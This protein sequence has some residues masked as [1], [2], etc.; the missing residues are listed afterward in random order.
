MAGAFVP[1]RVREKA[2]P[3]ASGKIRRL[4]IPT[5]PANREVAPSG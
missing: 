1:Q 2:I 4:G 5:E 3:K